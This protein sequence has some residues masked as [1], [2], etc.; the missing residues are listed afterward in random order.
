MVPA[1]RWSTA[2]AR[3]GEQLVDRRLQPRLAGWPSARRGSRRRP[4]SPTAT[5]AIVVPSASWRSATTLAAARASRPAETRLLRRRRQRLDADEAQ[6]ARDAGTSGPTCESTASTT[7]APQLAAGPRQPRALAVRLDAA[8]G[9]ALAHLGA[10]QREQPAAERHR[11]D[12]AVFGN[13]AARRPASRFPTA[14][15]TSAASRQS[16][17]KPLSASHSAVRA[18]SAS[19]ALPDGA[20]R[21]LPSTRQPQS[22]CRRSRTSRR[23]SRRFSCDSSHNRSARSSPTASAIGVSGCK[24]PVTRNPVLRPVAPAATRCPSSTTTRRPAR[25]AHHA[26]DAPRMPAPTMATSHSSRVVE[27]ENQ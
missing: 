14:R 25:A 20:V 17:A 16:T 8:H 22:T 21:Q 19:A 10:R 5:T 15:R 1:Q 11:V 26:V 2:A 27:R 6:L 3:R 9:D 23:S 24:P 7:T 12:A 18:H 4:R 13:V